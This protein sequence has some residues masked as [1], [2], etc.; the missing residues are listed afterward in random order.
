M[1][2]DIGPIRHNTAFRRLFASQ[3]IRESK[4]N[5]VAFS[6]PVRLHGFDLFRP[7]FQLGKIIQQFIRVGGNF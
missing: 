5:A 1:L 6:N 4:A 3:F 2:L 7:A